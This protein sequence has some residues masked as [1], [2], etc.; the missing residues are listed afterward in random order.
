MK[1]IRVYDETG[2]YIPVISSEMSTIFPGWGAFR[3]YDQNNETHCASRLGDSDPWIELEYSLKNGVGVLS[4]MNYGTPTDKATLQ[5]FKDRDLTDIL[6][7]GK[8]DGDKVEQSWDSESV[9]FLLLYV[10]TPVCCGTSEMNLPTS[11]SFGVNI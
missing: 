3:C 11:V 7:E 8:F 1:E 2:K 4:V 10:Y 9:C 6:W 5:I